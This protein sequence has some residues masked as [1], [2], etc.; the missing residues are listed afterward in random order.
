MSYRAVEVAGH[1]GG[2]SER[3]QKLLLDPLVLL[4][5]PR[6]RLIWIGAKWRDGHQPDELQAL[7]VVDGGAQVVDSL[8]VA[9]VH[10]APR[11]VTI[12]ADLYID[13]QWL[14]AAALGQR[15]A[16]GPG[17]G[18]DHLAAVDGVHGVRPVR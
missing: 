16:R 17:Q 14:R 7:G 5:Q 2:D 15:L 3:L 11:L 4:G 13:P 8:R 10:P 18:G 9:D 12:E 1:S 6:E